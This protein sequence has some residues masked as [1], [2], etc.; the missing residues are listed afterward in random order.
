MDFILE[1]LAIGEYDEAVSPPGKITALLCVA[2]ERDL[3]SPRLPYRKVPLVDMQPVP[4]TLLLE[5]IEWI[6]KTTSAGRCVL[7]FCNTGNSRS[8]SAVI[9]FLCVVLG[10]SF[11]RAVEH[12]AT[13]RPGISLLPDLITSIKEIRT[14]L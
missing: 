11:G 4:P 8:P 6:R 1:N 5:A 10:Y 9:A 3:R 2:Q 12:V 13:K 7:V 14:R